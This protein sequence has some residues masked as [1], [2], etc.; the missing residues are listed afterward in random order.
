M[1]TNEQFIQEASIK[2]P[3]IEIL[4]TYQGCKIKILCRCKICGNEWLVTPTNILSGKGCPN[5]RVIKSYQHTKKDTKKFIEA[6][7]KVHGDRYDYSKVNYV[8]AKTKVEIV[9]PVHGSF[10]QIPRFHIQGNGCPR[11]NG[12]IKYITSDFI[13]KAKSI[14]GDKYDYSKVDYVNTITPVK[15][16]CSKHGEFQQ[17]PRD[18]IAGCGCPMCKSSKGEILVSQILKDLNIQYI[19]QYT[20]KHKINNKKVI[21][22]FVIKVN[23][24]Y[25]IIEY[26]GIQHYQSVIHFGGEEIFKQQVIRDNGLRELCKQYD[27]PLLE[28][29][30]QNPPDEVNTLVTDFCKQLQ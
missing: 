22:D 5:C 15:I 21:V 26:N 12:G 16:I 17:T 1:K 8:N 19:S 29:S 3:N 28:I 11:C 27:V 18:H 4:G 14:H 25:A 23:N 10:W 20:L 7:K 2:N 30:Y 9:C 13:N 24:T 6:A